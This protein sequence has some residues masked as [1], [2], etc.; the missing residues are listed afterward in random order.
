MRV[1]IRLVGM[2]AVVGLAA[3]TPQ[4]G[5]SP[6]P[7][8]FTPSA[9][10]SLEPTATPRP[11][12]SPPPIKGEAPPYPYTLPPDPEVGPNEVA[13]TVLTKGAP[14]SGIP[15]TVMGG[16]KTYRVTTDAKGVYRVKDLAAGDYY[17]HFYNDSDNNKVGFWKTL[18]LKVTNEHGA[19][20]P[21]WDVFLI[22]M[23]NKPGQGAGVSFP[24]TATFEPYPL[25]ITYRFRIHDRGGPGGQALY[26]SDKIPAKGVRSFRFTGVANQGTTGTLG[27]GR[28]LWGYQWDAGT[29]GE[30]GCLFQDFVTGN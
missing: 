12:T 21:A 11:V 8:K 3:C 17:A 28:Y 13:G 18:T 23:Q 24:F 5:T 2:V 29:A 15:L 22:G 10:P 14:A 27:P 9:V 25:A 1:P 6:T 26:V 7:Y 4:P 30:G 19:V 16:G 20:F